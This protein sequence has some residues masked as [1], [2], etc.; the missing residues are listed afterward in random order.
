MSLVVFR[1]TDVGSGCCR[2]ATATDPKRL[3]RGGMKTG[4][5]PGSQSLAGV[6]RRYAANEVCLPAELC[7]QADQAL[8]Q[9]FGIVAHCIERRGANADMAIPDVEPLSSQQVADSTTI[10]DSAGESCRLELEEFDI[11]MQDPVRVATRNLH[12]YVQRVNHGLT[13]LHKLLI[14]EVE[15]S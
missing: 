5:S 2:R 6:L 11:P 13:A 10:S 3:L 8:R 12:I 1:G 7:L 14:A 15:R 4:S 9:C